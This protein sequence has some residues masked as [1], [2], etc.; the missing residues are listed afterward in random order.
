MYAI[1]SYYV[2]RELGMVGGFDVGLEMSGSINAF[3]DMIDVMYHGGK[4]HCSES[5]LK[6]LASIGERLFLTG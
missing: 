4:W 1:R 5:F 3:N 6:R 2:I